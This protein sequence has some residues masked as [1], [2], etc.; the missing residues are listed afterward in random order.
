MNATHTLKANAERKYIAGQ[1]VFHISTPEPMNVEVLETKH[2][3]AVVLDDEGTPCEVSERCLGALGQAPAPEV[4][5]IDAPVFEGASTADEARQVHRLAVAELMQA[6]SGG[7][8]A[9]TRAWRNELDIALANTLALISGAA[10]MPGRKAPAPAAPP[11]AVEYKAPVAKAP[12]LPR[13]TA[14][15]ADES[16]EVAAMAAVASMPAW[17][18][19]WRANGFTWVRSRS[20]AIDVHRIDGQGRCN[21][22]A[23]A[24]GRACWA[25]ACAGLV[26]AFTAAVYE[27]GTEAAAKALWAR[28]DAKYKRLR[29]KGQPLNRKGAI[30]EFLAQAK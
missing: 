25:L 24:H 1:N 10:V 17:A 13:Q 16:A 8:S 12:V 26:G 15:L 6:V 7:L 23:G 22:H 19:I 5:A 20:N 14:C 21:C 2:G 4:L 18:P 30:L 9:Q 28:V 11:E 3:R 29:V 27:C